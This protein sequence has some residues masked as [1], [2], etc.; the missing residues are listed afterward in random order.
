M[1]SIWEHILQNKTA[2]QQWG[3][4]RIEKVGD[5]PRIEGEGIPRI[6]INPRMSPVHPI[7]RENCPDWSKL[8]ERWLQ[9]Y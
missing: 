4:P 9:K 3:R 6:M 7:G 5:Q 1:K 8:L 2:N